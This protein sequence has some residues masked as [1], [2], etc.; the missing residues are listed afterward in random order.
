MKQKSEDVTATHRA[1]GSLGKDAHS[2]TG[3]W[4]RCQ[5]KPTACAR[6]SWASRRRHTRAL[7]PALCFHAGPGPGCLSDSGRLGALA[8]GP[9]GPRHLHR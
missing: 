8:G 1:A 6:L 4:S 5:T 9:A 2:T 3:G 7:G